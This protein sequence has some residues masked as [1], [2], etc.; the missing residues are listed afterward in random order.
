MFWAM[1]LRF[2]VTS[3]KACIPLAALME[4]GLTIAATLLWDAMCLLTSY[5]LL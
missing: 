4:H 2:M 1:V 5:T 3:H